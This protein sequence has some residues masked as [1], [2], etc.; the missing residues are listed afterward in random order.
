MA[1]IYLDG[2]KIVNTNKATVLSLT[3]DAKL[4]FAHHINDMYAKI[5]T[6]INKLRVLAKQGMTKNTLI[7]IYKACVRPAMTYAPITWINTSTSQKMKL[8][9]ACNT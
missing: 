4:S 3:V 5:W 7:K 1:K 2:K 8:L 6:R 9:S